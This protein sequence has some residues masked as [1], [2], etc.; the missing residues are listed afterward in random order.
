MAPKV[1]VRNPEEQL[2]D[3]EW[4][5][6]T[7]PRNGRVQRPAVTLDHN[8]PT[9]WENFKSLFLLVDPLPRFSTALGD[10]ERSN[11]LNYVPNRRIKNLP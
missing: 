1:A 2:S 3:L 5:K 9:L 11:Q 8:L 7:L 6:W 10:R 4:T